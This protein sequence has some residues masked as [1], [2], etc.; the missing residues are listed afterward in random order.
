MLDG[1]AHGR[2]QWLLSLRSVASGLKKPLLAR[3]ASFCICCVIY[4][5]FQRFERLFNFM[6]HSIYRLNFDKFRDTAP[7]DPL[8]FSGR[9]IE[10]LILLLCMGCKSQKNTG[11]VTIFGEDY[12]QAA[13][14][15]GPKSLMLT[16]PNPSF[17]RKC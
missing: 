16:F 2:S 9:K 6:F 10:G 7:L 14:M 8:H 12:L 15:S 1:K 4:T 3:F 13:L 5:F 11:K 17:I